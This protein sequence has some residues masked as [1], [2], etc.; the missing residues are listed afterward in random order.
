MGLCNFYSLIYQWISHLIRIIKVVSYFFCIIDNLIKIVRV[1]ITQIATL[2]ALYAHFNN[3]LIL[4]YNAGYP[5]VYIVKPPKFDSPY[6]QFHVLLW[7]FRP[8]FFSKKWRRPVLYVLEGYFLFLTKNECVK[9]VFPRGENYR[10][11]YKYK[12][13]D[14]TLRF[15]TGKLSIF[16]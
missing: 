16:P 4:P 13:G 5:S 14:P 2:S 12:N 10:N 3:K 6:L 11:N 7:N 9:D 1:F 8:S 15:T